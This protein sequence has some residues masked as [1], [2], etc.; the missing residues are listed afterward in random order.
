MSGI[1][2]SAVHETIISGRFEAVGKVVS[3]IVINCVSL[4]VAPHPSVTVNN[5][6]ITRGQVPDKVSI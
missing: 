1:G 2:T 5:L 4:A 6:E 3:C